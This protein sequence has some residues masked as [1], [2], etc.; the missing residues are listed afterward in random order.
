LNKIL[1]YLNQSLF[2]LSRFEQK[3]TTCFQ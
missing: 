3:T 1:C 2:G